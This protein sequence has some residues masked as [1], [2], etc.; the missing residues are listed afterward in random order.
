MSR[1]NIHRI[2]LP[3]FLEV[4]FMPYIVHNSLLF[5]KC[6]FHL[7]THVDSALLNAGQIAALLITWDQRDIREMFHK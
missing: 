5:V 7:N 3:F 4:P 1:R 6:H 2:T